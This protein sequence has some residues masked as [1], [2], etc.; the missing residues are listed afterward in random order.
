MKAE[1]LAERSDVKTAAPS[2]AN[3]ADWM[4]ARSA[5]NSAEHLVALKAEQSA[6][7]SAGSTVVQRVAYWVVMRAAP[8]AERKVVHWAAR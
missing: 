5:E 1:N 8:K 3:S 4:V 7:S 2:V 6:A